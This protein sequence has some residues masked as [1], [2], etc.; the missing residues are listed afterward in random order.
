MLGNLVSDIALSNIILISLF[1]I[2]FY[3]LYMCHMSI[4]NMFSKIESL[5]NKIYNQVEEKTPKEVL[6]T[7]PE[8]KIPEEKIPEEDTEEDTDLEDITE[9]KIP[10][11][12]VPEKKPTRRKINNKDL[13]SL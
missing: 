5:E 7:I 4:S 1:L 8:E 2:I 10:E 3:I 11:E 6:Q 13:K 9:E 12:K